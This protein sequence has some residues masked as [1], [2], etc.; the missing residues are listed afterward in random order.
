MGHDRDPIVIYITTPKLPRKSF[1]IVYIDVRIDFNE[2][3]NGLDIV[4]PRLVSQGY[5]LFSSS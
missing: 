3:N 2:R 1:A 4:K 5:G